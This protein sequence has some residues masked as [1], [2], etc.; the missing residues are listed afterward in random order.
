MVPKKKKEGEEKRMAQ[1]EMLL[2][3]AETGLSCFFFTIFKK[4]LFCL[5]IYFVLLLSMF[6]EIMSLRNLEHVLAREEE[7]KKKVVVHKDT[8]DGPIVRFCS[9]DGNRCT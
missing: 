4:I 2:E 7:V 9:R 8:Y 6:P 1:E 3:A 5:L